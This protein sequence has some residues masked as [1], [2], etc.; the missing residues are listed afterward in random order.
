MNAFVRKH[1]QS[2]IGSLSG[3]DRLVLRGKLRALSYVDGLLGF[4]NAAGILLKDFGAYAEKATEA[5]KAASLLTAQKLGRP[6]QYLDSPSVRK[7]ELARE[8]ATRDGIREGLICVLTAVEPCWG[9][10]IQRNKEAQRLELVRRR[11][12]CLHLY[13][14][15]LHRSFGLMHVRLQ[16]WL[17]FDLQIWMNGREWLSR[18]LDGNGVGYCRRGNTFTWIEDLV[19]AQ[20]RATAQLRSNWPKLL[21]TLA[22][23]IHPAHPEIFGDFVP[24]YYW[25]VYQSEWATDI[26]FRDP[27][28]LSR[29]YPRLVH[30]GMAHMGSADVMRFLGH[31]IP[32]HGFVPAKFQGEVITDLR[33]RPEGIRIKHGVGWNSIKLY[34]KAGSVLRVETTINRPQ[35]FKVYR[36][37][38]GDEH[39]EWSW[40]PMRQGIADL[41]RR[42]SVSAAANERYLAA[43]AAIEDKTPLRDLMGRLAR[44]AE[45][46][47][48]RARPLNPGA[49]ADADLLAAANRGEFAIR[50]FK[51]QDLRKLL[52][53][54]DPDDKR[55]NRR[56]AA[57]VTRLIRLLRAHGLVIK[58]QRTHRYMVTV[59]GR[60]VITSILA[61]RN[62]SIESLVDQAA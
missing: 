34:D 42:A 57:R 49:A 13:H 31:K 14:Y 59:E 11:R 3:F 52:F 23:E 36:P 19:W 43:L 48:K 53:G 46:N 7:D 12:K 47:G 9:F 24:E 60:Q 15:L 45:L 22:A 39:G 55:E 5:L 30:H 54:E 26:M 18:E 1:A 56:R 8:I 2:V 16:T 38:E 10:D 33:Q 4:L 62:A 6:I 25:S 51:N 40:R 58:V 37:R 17:P 50:G 29:V 21:E 44:P 32:A 61:A 27:E 20:Q 28:S 41:H 35:D